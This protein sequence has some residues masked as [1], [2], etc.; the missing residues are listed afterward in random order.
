MTTKESTYYGRLMEGNLQFSYVSPSGEKK[1]LT[2][3]IACECENPN[4][5]LECGADQLAAKITRQVCEKY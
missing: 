3:L 2:A 1:H 4:P 5:N